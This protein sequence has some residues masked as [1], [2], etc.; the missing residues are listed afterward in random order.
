MK[1][2]FDSFLIDTDG[3][4]LFEN[5]ETVPV[6]PLAFDLLSYLLKNRTRI[7]AKDELFENLWS[8]K[9][10]SDAALAS[11]LKDARKAVGDSGAKQSVI[12]T[13]HGRGFQ[14]VAN[15]SSIEDLTEHTKDDFPKRLVSP[16]AQKPSVT[17]KPFVNLD[18]ESGQDY[19]VTGLMWDIWAALVKIPHLVL[20][21]GESQEYDP[22]K[23]SV[24]ELGQVFNVQYVI[25]GGVRKSGNRVR[26]NVE[27]VEVSTGKKVWGDRYDG[28]LDDLFDIQDRITENITISLNIKLVFGEAARYTRDKIK[29]PEALD[30][31]YRGQLAL[32]G[33]TRQELLDAQHFLEEI[34]RLEPD[35]P[36]GYAMAAYAYW[37]TAYKGLSSNQGETLRKAV[38][39]SEESLKRSDTSGYPNLIL[40]HYYLYHQDLPGALDELERGMAFRPSCPGSNSLKAAVLIYL[41][42]ASEAIEYAEQAIRLQPI[43]PSMYPAIVASAYFGCEQ[44]REAILAAQEAINIDDKNIDPHLYR[45]ASLVGLGQLR[46]ARKAASTVLKLK[47]NFKLDAFARTQPFQNTEDLDHLI[48]KLKTAGL[49]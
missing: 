21:E 44:Y 36:I 17:I 38:E 8:G 4:Q 42:R 12:K 24:E 41:G 23:M 6:E 14:F 47:P 48:S 3:Y 30:N 37:M 20:V 46:E 31:L 28:S 40:A 32:Y 2:S 15:V 39:M 35:S 22:G 27:L 16:T 26:V 7:V 5:G 13:I 19:F 49:G 9:V 43:N 29:S 45:A 25:Q 1:Y 10:V 18:S 11:R 34:I 33:T